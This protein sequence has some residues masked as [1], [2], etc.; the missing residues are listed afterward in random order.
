MH[1][2]VPQST[3]LPSLSNQIRMMIKLVV[4]V[5]KE[6]RYISLVH[7]AHAVPLRGMLDS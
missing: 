7:L 4:A 5:F 3:V 1:E 6:R 2:C